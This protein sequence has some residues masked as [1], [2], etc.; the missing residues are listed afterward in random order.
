[1]PK[2]K[3]INI[4]IFLVLSQDFILLL[5]AIAASAMCSLDW[6][7]SHENISV[8]IRKQQQKQMFFDAL[9]LHFLPFKG[10]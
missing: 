9:S 6:N 2:G 3:N 7:I 10:L 8:P 4:G 5:S 1:M